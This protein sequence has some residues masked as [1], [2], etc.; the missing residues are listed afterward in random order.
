M[1]N[2]AEE[3]RYTKE[4]PEILLKIEDL[5]LEA[6]AKLEAAKAA[7]I[8]TKAMTKVAKEFLMDSSKLADKYADEEQLDMFRVSV[9]IRQRKGIEETVG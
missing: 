7:G 3:K 5:K 1:T 4:L 8:N 9:G 6:K 2:S